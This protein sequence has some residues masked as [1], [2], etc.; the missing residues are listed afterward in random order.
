MVLIKTIA[1]DIEGAGM[2][3]I[4][5]RRLGDD[6][7]PYKIT[8]FPP[9]HQIFVQKSHQQSYL[10]IHKVQQAPRSNKR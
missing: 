1:D 2:H 3:V 4:E 6:I 7:S 9:L 5:V 8:T 10:I